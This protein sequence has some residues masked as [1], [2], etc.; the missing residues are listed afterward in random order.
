[1]CMCVCMYTHSYVLTLV[2]R[3]LHLLGFQEQFSSL[4]KG[5]A[6]SHILHLTLSSIVHSIRQLLFIRKEFKERFQV[7]KL[8][9]RTAMDLVIFLQKT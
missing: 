3:H 5:S 7:H 2:K 1:M 4:R 8:C 6:S 9:G